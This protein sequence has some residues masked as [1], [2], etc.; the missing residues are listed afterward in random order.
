MGYRGNKASSNKVTK[1]IAGFYKYLSLVLI[2]VITIA[3]LIVVFFGAFKENKELLTT[4]VIAPPANWFNFENFKRAWVEGDMGLGFL[5]TIIILAASIT[6][7]IL[8]GTMTAYVLS[9]FKFRCKGLVKFLFL[10]ASLI[11]S[12]TMQ[13]S[14]FQIIVGLHLYN[15]RMAT[16]LL[17]A[18]T[19]IISI[20]IFLQF[21]NGIS[22]SIDEA[23][24]ID[25]ASFPRIFFNII[26]PLLRPAIVT[27]III[28]EIGF[29]NEFYTP[30]L[31]MKKPSLHV[32]ST[33]LYAFQGP[34]GTQWEVICAAC[35]ITMIPT[36][37]IFLILQKQIYSGL[38]MGSVKG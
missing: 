19:D 16:I 7:T 8:T 27:V 10:L 30:Y 14:I 20:Y 29:Y 38:T 3:P 36:L 35:I 1:Y 31:Y 26:L 9:R 6:A 18:G 17:Y 34:Y 12:I 23:A 33:S 13:M 2:V 21:L 25:V 28:K 32:I 15:T 4:K 11:P 22:Y 37:I 5:N 24:I